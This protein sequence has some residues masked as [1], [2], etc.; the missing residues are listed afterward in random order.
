MFSLI[1]WVVTGWIAGSLANWFLPSASVQPGWQTVATGVAGSIV[2][3]VVYSL[4]NGS[5]YS[6]AGFVFSTVGRSSA[7]SP[8]AGTH[9]R[10]AACD[11][12]PLADCVPR[13]ALG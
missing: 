1:G 3:G 4:I 5:D 12:L 11:S 8:T 13:L 7:W 9:R 6:P 10:E 2:G